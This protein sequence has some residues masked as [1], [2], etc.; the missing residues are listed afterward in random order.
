MRSSLRWAQTLLALAICLGSSGSVSADDACG[1]V[2]SLD[3]HGRSTTSYSLAMPPASATQERLATLVLLPGS[4]GY[5]ALDGNGCA[6]RLAGNWLVRSRELF[7]KA[8]FATALVDAPSDHRGRDGLRGFRLAAPHAEDIG[9]VVADLRKRAGTP[10]WLIG[11]SRG[12]ISA[13]NAASRLTGPAAPDGLILASP[14]TAGRDSGYKPWLWQTVLRTQLEVIRVPV[15]VVAHAADTCIRSPPGLAGS[16]AVRTNGSR[17]QTVTVTGG[18]KGRRGATPE[19]ACEGRS[20]HG[21]LGQEAEV[22]A[23]IAR[24][25]RGE[26]Y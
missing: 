23:G 14:V 7:H 20:H 10:V 18:R 21:F 26:R 22:V 2:V 19:G 9:Q 15:L 25:V 11:T 4:S 6:T 13:A 8:G 1:E 17:E 12:T 24:F 3:S 5:V 16:I